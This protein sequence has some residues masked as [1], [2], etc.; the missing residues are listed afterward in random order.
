MEKCY[1]EVYLISKIL[2]FIISLFP[3]LPYGFL[4]LGYMEY[5][6]EKQL[7]KKYNLNE[8]DLKNF[9]TFLYELDE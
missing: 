2:I 1:G 3:L 7:V 4:F 9:N 6:G 8:T 5:L